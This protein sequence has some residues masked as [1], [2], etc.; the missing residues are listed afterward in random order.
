LIWSP[1][2]IRYLTSTFKRFGSALVVVVAP[3]EDGHLGAVNQGLVY[4]LVLD[5]L[6]SDS[7]FRLVFLSQACHLQWCRSFEVSFCL[8]AEVEPIVQSLLEILVGS[9]L[10]S[11]KARNELPS[12]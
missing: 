12:P 10:N 4:L 6:P 1:G 7:P 9:D 11:R 3:T 8:I 2:V 5:T